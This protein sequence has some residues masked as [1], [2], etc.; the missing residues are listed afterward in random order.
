MRWAYHQD[1]T[2]HSDEDLTTTWGWLREESQYTPQCDKGLWGL[3][4]SMSSI[5]V[6]VNLENDPDEPLSPFSPMTAPRLWSE[7]FLAIRGGC[8]FLFLSSTTVTSSELLFGR[9][10]PWLSYFSNVPD[11]S[12]KDRSGGYW[13]ICRFLARVSDDHFPMIRTW[14]VLNLPFNGLPYQKNEDKLQL[15]KIA[16]TVPMVIWRSNMAQLLQPKIQ[17]KKTIMKEQDQWCRYE[18]CTRPPWCRSPGQSKSVLIHM[19]MPTS[20]V[21]GMRNNSLEAWVLTYMNH[22]G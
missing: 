10:E 14:E 19:D 18:N 9:P 8:R 4:T 2:S 7:L 3:T 11:L 17:T 22:H 15:P 5:Q 6:P 1:L 13:F 12:C 16:P 21:I 20:W